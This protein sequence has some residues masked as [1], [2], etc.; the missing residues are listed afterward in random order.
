MR[1]NGSP[2]SLPRGAEAQSLGLAPSFR[3]L[4][5]SEVEAILGVELLA[6]VEARAVVVKPYT[7][8][9][10]L[11]S[12]RLRRAVLAQGLFVKF[13]YLRSIVE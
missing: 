7:N 10:L 4:S 8:V 3:P 2:T 5:N 9:L 11:V 13:V 6:Q 1:S 12:Q